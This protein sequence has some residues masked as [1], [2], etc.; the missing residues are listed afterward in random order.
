MLGIQT[1]YQCDA[2]RYHGGKVV[3]M[4]STHGTNVYDFLLE[5]IM[6]VDSY[7]EGL[8]VAWALTNHEDV[9]VLTEFLKE[10]KTRTGDIH[11]E[12]FMS[13]D[14]QQ[15]YNAWHIVFGGSPS[16]ILCMWHVDRSWR[17]SLNEHVE[18]SQCCIEIYRQL[19]VLLMEQNKT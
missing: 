17:K 1:E 16:K 9:T 4:D 19:R 18:N 13:D 2:M 8:P 14:A 10:L 6:V 7:G 3:C 11:P 12:I 15:F 5:P